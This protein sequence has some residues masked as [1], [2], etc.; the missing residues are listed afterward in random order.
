MPAAVRLRRANKDYPEAGIKKGVL[1]FEYK[2]KYKP[3]IKCATRPTEEQLKSFT[4]V[5]YAR[6]ANE[7]AAG[8]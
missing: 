2:H 6:L 1:Y 7:K 4:R 8:K 3:W 5:E